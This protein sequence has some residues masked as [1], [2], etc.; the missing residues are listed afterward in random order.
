MSGW[1]PSE[2]WGTWS[3]GSDYS[4][5]AFR[6]ERGFISGKGVKIILK[7]R[8]L[9]NSDTISYVRMKSENV[10][11]W[12]KLDSF[13]ELI[14]SSEILQETGTLIRLEFYH[15]NATTPALLGIS[16]DKRCL[17]CGVDNISFEEL[18]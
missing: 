10:Q 6:L 1:Y 3:K 8:Y 13:T 11:E 4:Y 7:T 17:G 5:I 9:E 2:K 14:I 16:N 15:K 18:E 12:I